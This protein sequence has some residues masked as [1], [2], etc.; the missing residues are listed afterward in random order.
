MTLGQMIRRKRESIGINQ[1]SLAKTLK[2]SMG[3]LSEIERDVK[4]PSPEVLSALS[5]TLDL[6]EI[7]NWSKKAQTIV[8][9]SQTMKL[10]DGALQVT[11]EE[12]PLPISS[13][14]E[15][16]MVFVV[17][18]DAMAGANIYAGDRVVVS[19]TQNLPHRK[20]AAIRMDGQ[21]YV[22]GF[23]VYDGKVRLVAASAYPVIEVEDLKSIEVLGEVTTVLKRPD[24]GFFDVNRRNA[25][26]E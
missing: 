24:L 12:Q 16:S 10:V 20:V 5:E 6:P 17:G 25:T 7:L 11:I 23:L 4:V 15:G 21:V 13:L 1:V 14:I 9:Y 19:P 2:I 26:K 22:R 18:N 8:V 3:Y